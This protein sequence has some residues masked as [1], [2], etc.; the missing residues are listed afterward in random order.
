MFLFHLF[1]AGA[2][3]D[4]V[5]VITL[6]TDMKMDSVTLGTITPDCCKIT[7]A[8]TL[9]F[10]KIVC[11]SLE[12]VTDISV[13]N[14]RLTGTIN[15]VALA[16][17]PL[18]TLN[19][20]G[21]DLT[22]P[23]LALPATL[24]QFSALNSKL[25][26]QLP[27]LPDSLTL[28]NLGYNQFTDLSPFSA[29]SQLKT[30]IMSNN[31]LITKN[32]VFPNTLVEINM[33]S[34]QLSGTLSSLPPFLTQLTL[35]NNQFTG[36]LPPLPSSLTVV[37]V[38]QNQF[39]GSIST[40]PPLVTIFSVHS[41]EFS[42]KLPTPPS[43]LAFLAISNNKFT[44]ELPLLSKVTNLYAQMNN[45]EG[46]LSMESPV[47]LFIQGN[48]VSSLSIKK[49]TSLTA[50]DVRYNQL[51]NEQL[52]IFLGTFCKISD[53]M[54]TLPS[55]TTGTTA[56]TEQES[57]TTE[58]FGYTGVDKNAQASKDT[59]LALIAVA[60][61]IFLIGSVA[62]TFFL[63]KRGRSKA[64]GLSSASALDSN[65]LGPSI[66]RLNDQQFTTISLSPSVNKK[67]FGYSDNE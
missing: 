29:K 27:V 6:L 18:I 34:N 38:S 58:G 51:S 53:Q 50:C 48:K 8:E 42:G 37:D 60:I 46:L 4:C 35:A 31:K 26:G 52:Q 63:V 28:L 41:N 15:S 12:R 30:L 21:N 1:V 24:K 32:I 39:T 13:M 9:K 66:Q 19:L 62:I 23:I 57:T 22:G 36:S 65:R 43:S 56:T 7:N 64:Q 2:S 61:V 3:I 47:A 11:D 54:V 44:G 14:L 45:F 59:T 25:D 67:R 17:I 33:Y 49:V 10:V 16:A 5:N 20:N 40:F 55:A